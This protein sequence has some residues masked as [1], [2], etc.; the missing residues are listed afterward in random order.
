MNHTVDAH[1]IKRRIAVTPYDVEDDALNWLKT[2]YGTRETSSSAIAE[3]ALRDGPVLAKSGRRYS[4]DM[5]DL[6]STT[7]T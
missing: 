5:L 6:S 2:N 3:T 4:A 1:N 7:L